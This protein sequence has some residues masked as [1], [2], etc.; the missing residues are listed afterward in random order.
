MREARLATARMTQA[1]IAAAATDLFPA[2]WSLL[3]S[4]LP[5]NLR[6]ARTITLRRRRSK[7]NGSRGC[8]GAL[9]HTWLHS[10]WRRGVVV[11]V[12][13]RMNAVILRRPRLVLGVWDG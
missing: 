3:C 9:L 8:F 11:S 6:A 2:S 7:M 1:P 13:R 5:E 12:V 10:G 4:Y